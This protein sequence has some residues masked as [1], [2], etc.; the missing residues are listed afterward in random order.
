VSSQCFPET[1]RGIHQHSDQAAVEIFLPDKDSGR[2]CNEYGSVQ[3]LPEINQKR[4]Y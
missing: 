1:E 2:H 3:I 4:N